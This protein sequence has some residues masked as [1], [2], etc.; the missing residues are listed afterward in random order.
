MG[1]SKFTPDRLLIIRH[2]LKTFRKL[3]LFR[4]IRIRIMAATTLLIVVIVSAVVWSWAT[5]ESEVYRTSERQQAQT[6]A[7]ALSNAWT[8]ELENQNWSQIRL[9]LNL[10]LERNPSFLYILVSDARLFNQIVA[11][12][13]DDFQ[14]QFFPDVVSA[15]VTEL[16]WKVYGGTNLEETY[17]LRNVEF[18]K[19]LVRG[20]RG[21]PMIEVAA[22]MRNSSG[23]RVGTLR[24]GISLREVNRA[25]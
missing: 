14:E 5:N 9:G 19:G 21:E 6:L 23:E 18:P 17:L 11:A 8:N 7:V 12:A 3:A 22:D 24:I 4:S 10:L 2:F 1:N 20:R 15:K 13:P 16:A 25:V